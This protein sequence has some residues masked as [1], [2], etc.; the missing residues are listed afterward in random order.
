MPTIASPCS[1]LLKVRFNP[2]NRRAHT[3]LGIH[4]EQLVL[5]DQAREQ[6][7]IAI[8]LQPSY[9]DSYYRIGVIEG[10]RKN[11]AES[12]EYFQKLWALAP[13]NQTAEILLRLVLHGAGPR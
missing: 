12:L 8:K 1:F 2:K 6:Y 7:E 10:E 3:H 9:L 13:E 4:L 11:F 5:V